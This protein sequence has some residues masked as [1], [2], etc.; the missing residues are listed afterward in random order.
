MMGRLGILSCIPLIECAVPAAVAVLLWVLADAGSACRL[1]AS[2]TQLH[3]ARHR[4]SS[5]KPRVLRT[6]AC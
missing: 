1:T 4:F 3:P 2:W 6:G 5:R